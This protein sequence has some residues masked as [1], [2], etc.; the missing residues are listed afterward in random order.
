MGIVLIGGASTE[1]QSAETIGAKAANLARMTALGL[2]VPPSFVL[3]VSEALERLAASEQAVLEGGDGW[4][5]DADAQLEAAASAVFRSWMSERAQTY[6]RLQKL[7]H[8]QG[9]AVTVQAMVFGNGGLASGAGVAFSRDPSTG[10]TRPIVDLVLDAQGEDVVSGRRMPD[11]EET[12]ARAL[13]K[14]TGELGEV[15]RGWNENFATCRMPSSLLKMATCGSCKHA[16]PSGRHAQRSG[17]PS[18]SCMRG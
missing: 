7:E 2:P 12:I 10:V 9:T 15:L 13:P 1:K 17:S 18:I 14:L 6:R 4:L 3:P 16:R 8:L 5:E 11:T